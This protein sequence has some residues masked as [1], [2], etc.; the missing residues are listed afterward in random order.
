MSSSYGGKDP[1][2]G[3]AVDTGLTVDDTGA[4]APD[5]TGTEPEPNAVQFSLSEDDGDPDTPELIMAG[6]HATLALFAEGS[7]GLTEVAARTADGS[8]DT[9]T[10]LDPSTG[11]VRM[12]LD[13]ASGHTT[14]VL[15]DD[16]D[17]PSQFYYLT[18]DADGDYVDGHVTWI[19]GED[20]RLAHITGK[21][22][23]SGQLFAQLDDTTT[24]ESGSF[25]VTAS[26]ASN[27]VT[28]VGALV[29]EDEVFVPRA[30]LIF[31]LATED[32][33]GTAST[34]ASGMLAGTLKVAGLAGV[35]VALGASSTGVAA[36]A[37]MAG[38]A[39]LVASA[40]SNDIA[41]GIE[42]KFSSDAPFSQE[43]VDFV[44]GYLS[45]GGPGLIG[46]LESALD[47]VESLFD[48]ET[49]DDGAHVDEW[50]EREPGEFD[51]SDLLSGSSNWDLLA[52]GVADL[53]DGASDT[54]G[55]LTSDL[56]DRL[57]V[58][59]SAV[60]LDGLAV[61]QDS[62]TYDLDGTLDA[63]GHVVLS[64]DDIDG[65]GY[66]IDIEGDIDLD[67]V[68]DGTFEIDTGS[69]GTAS[70]DVSELGDC[71]TAV[72]S[73]GEGTF[74]FAHYVGIGPGTV[75]FS[76]DAYSIPDAFDLIGPGGRLFSTGG[77]VSGS[78]TEAVTVFED[79]PATVFVSVSAPNDGTAWEY[80]LGCIDGSRR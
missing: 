3:S 58:S 12:F 52:E 63:D 4:A 34:D 66:H 24:G 32:L 6:D 75:D 74:T 70:G 76:Y 51:D 36:A 48:G 73:G 5:D 2:T 68:F 18:F 77:L 59:D 79:G 1:D 41:N 72:G 33:A 55:E 35:A 67:G 49:E 53:W 60:D 28:P 61:W 16:P 22:A 15:Q 20:L 43:C 25:A 29:V 7:T 11:E 46:S 69:E 31:A 14:V 42:E 21:P 8:I 38:M 13:V 78:S 57:D 45:D 9:R 19:D 37:G 56:H 65:L 10:F 17:T 39:M 44:T 50:D 80:A 26:S 62:T 30:A 54:F 71:S 23:F 64:G 40:F 27:V 47:K